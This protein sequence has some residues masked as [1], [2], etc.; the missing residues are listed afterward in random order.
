MSFLKKVALLKN[1]LVSWFCVENHGSL[2]PFV[3]FKCDSLS[4][5]T[6]ETC[7]P[8]HIRLTVCPK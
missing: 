3:G 4:C 1:I 8:E 2:L 7:G 6:A 5:N